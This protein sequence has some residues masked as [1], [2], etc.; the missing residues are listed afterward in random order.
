VAGQTFTVT[1]ASGCTYN[2]APTTQSF[3]E[4]GGN[5]SISVTTGPTCPW[6][7][8]ADDDW[9]IIT[10]GA[11]GTGSGLT[12]YHV[13]SSNKKRNGTITIAG[14]TFTVKQED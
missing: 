12:R 5:G 1:Q 13:E 8:V 9:I 11:S 4:Q 10:A 2:I 14:K 6:T 7:A 3:S